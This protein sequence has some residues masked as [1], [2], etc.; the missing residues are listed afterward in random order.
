[1]GKIKSARIGAE[2]KIEPL[3]DDIERNKLRWYGHVMRM[4][5]DGIS[6]KYSM[7]QPQ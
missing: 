7:R 5:D 3:L 2:L 6:K 1:R 4:D